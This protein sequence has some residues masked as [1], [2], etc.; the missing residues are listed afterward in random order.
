MWERWNGWT[1]DKG[2]GDVGMNSFKHYAFGA[3]GEYLNG[4]VGGIMAASPGYKT[5]VIKPA[6]GE[7]LT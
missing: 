2:F 5:I 6:I 7:G 4:G 3:V 1:P